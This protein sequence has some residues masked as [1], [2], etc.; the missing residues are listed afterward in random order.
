MRSDYNDRLK[1]HL[2]IKVINVATLA[3]TET[4]FSFSYFCMLTI[5]FCFIVLGFM[6]GFQ[7]RRC[8]ISHINTGFI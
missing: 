2:I 8:G 1:N 7:Y 4:N 3:T 5:Y 6:D